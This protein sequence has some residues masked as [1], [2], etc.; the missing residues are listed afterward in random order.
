MI[1]AIDESGFNSS[2]RFYADFAAVLGMTP[3]DF[4]NGC[5]NADMRFAIGDLFGDQILVAASNKGISDSSATT[6]MISCARF[7]IVSRKPI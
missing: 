1:E 7:R 3:S 6:R 5:V 2:G 4:R